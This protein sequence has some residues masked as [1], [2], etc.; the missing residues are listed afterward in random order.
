MPSYFPPSRVG[1]ARQFSVVH[2]LDVESAAPRQV[3]VPGLASFE[4]PI[5]T[6]YI[7]NSGFGLWKGPGMYGN[8]LAMSGITSTPYPGLLDSSI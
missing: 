5:T 6:H 7:G 2:P 3:P 1:R 8:F 4:A